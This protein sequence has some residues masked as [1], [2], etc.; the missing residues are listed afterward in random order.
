M[1][2]PGRPKQPT[3]LRILRGNPSKEKIPTDEPQPAADRIAP[4]A[5]CTG[6]AADKFNELAPQLHAIGVLTNVDLDA[7]GR[8]CVIHV[9]WVKHIGI[10]QRGGD[11]L[12]GRDD[13]G[14][15]KYTQ[16]GPS[17]TLVRQ[18]GQTLLRLAQEFGLTPSSRTALSTT[19]AGTG[20]PLST[21]LQKNA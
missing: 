5:F 4:P 9:E 21:W 17:A 3:Q 6:A 16:V 12:I 1:A 2:K 15:V 11:I 10:C 8:Y 7:L 13:S 20:D 19:E 18:H 14:R